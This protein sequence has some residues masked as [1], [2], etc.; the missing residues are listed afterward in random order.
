[1]ISSMVSRS[2]ARRA[3]WAKASLRQFFPLHLQAQG[4]RVRVGNG[5]GRIVQHGLEMRRSPPGDT[6]TRH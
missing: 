1:M 3:I 4:T 5:V 2:R 6:G